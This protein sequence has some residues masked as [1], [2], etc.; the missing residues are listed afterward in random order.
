MCHVGTVP[1][2]ATDIADL[3]FYSTEAQLIVMLYVTSYILRDQ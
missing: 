2:R 1:R 3:L